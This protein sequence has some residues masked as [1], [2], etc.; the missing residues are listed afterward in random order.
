[1]PWGGCSVLCSLNTALM[2]R[3]TCSNPVLVSYGTEN[4][5]KLLTMVCKTHHGLALP[6]P[7]THL[8]PISPQVHDMTAILASICPHTQQVTPCHTLGL[9]SNGTFLFWAGGA[10]LGG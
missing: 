6:T 3:C 5:I 1:M 7:Q 9:G 2:P 8:L 4:K 10:F